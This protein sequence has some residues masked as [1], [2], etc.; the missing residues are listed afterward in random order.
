MFNNDQLAIRMDNALS[1]Q[2]MNRL[3]DQEGEN[4]FNE[5]SLRAALMLGLPATKKQ[6]TDYVEKHGNPNEAVLN[7]KIL[8]YNYA[9]AGN[10]GMT[11]TEL[12]QQDLKKDLPIAY[13]AADI[14]VLKTAFNNLVANP[15]IQLFKDRQDSPVD[16]DSLTGMIKSFEANKGAAIGAVVL[17]NVYLNL[18]TEYNIDLFKPFKLGNVPYNGFGGKIINGERKQDII[19]SLVTMETDNAKERFIS[20]LGLNI[21]AVGMAANMISLGIPLETTLLLLNSAEVRDLY[22]L[23]QNKVDNTSP[24]LK[25]LLDS[26]IA[27]LKAKVTEEKNKNGKVKFA[28]VNKDLL[29]KAVDST[30]DLSDNE[31]LQILYAFSRLNKIKNWTA[32]MRPAVVLSQGL[33]QNVPTTKKNIKDLQELFGKDAQADVTSI[34]KSKTWQSTNLKVFSQIYQD[35]LPNVLLTMS[36][37]FAEILSP[38]NDNLDIDNNKFGFD[39]AAKVEQDL[40]SYLTIKSYKHLLNNSSSNAAPVT[41]NLIYPGPINEADLS[42]VKMIRD[43]KTRRSENNEESNFFLDSFVGTEYATD[44]GNTTGLNIATSNTWRRLNAANLIDLQTSFAKLYGGLETRDLAISILHYM[45]VKDGLQLKYGSLLKA[46]SPFVME[47][48][49]NNVNTVELALK[50]I[51]PYEKA[52]GITKE[53]LIKE[54]KE[55]YLESNPTGPI[56]RNYKTSDVEYLPVEEVVYIKDEMED[57]GKMIDYFRLDLSDAMSKTYKLFKRDEEADVVDGKV[58]YRLVPSMGSNQQFAAGF[59]GGPRLTYIQTRNINSN[60]P[61]NDVIRSEQPIQQTD[62]AGASVGVSAVETQQKQDILRT[63]GAIIEVTNN[64]VEVKENDEQANTNIADTAKALEAL[65]DLT[66]SGTFDEVANAEMENNSQTLDT[67]TEEQQSQENQLKLDLAESEEMSEVVSLEKWWSDNVA[68]NT[69]AEKK[70][71][72]QGIN[73]LQDAMFAYGDLFSQTELGEQELI[74]RLKCLL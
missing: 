34:F 23:S 51:I 43:E 67:R 21:H 37:E 53:E 62:E 46:M 7:N 36:P 1:P 41:N 39:T 44:N 22:D 58:V 71:S 42:I 18:L 31:R 69:E 40:L 74:D 27:S 30:K 11:G 49:L 70:M 4:K 24:N 35:L 60:T 59:V 16:V 55:G 25:M 63:P 29:V 3:T 47:K 5:D 8:D 52:F 65:S 19:S 6:F 48:Y 33:P 56:L 10:E 66:A 64:S 13:Q 15:D 38:V 28:Q 61:V 72:E 17:P 68:G 12:L 54:F 14:E 2:E 57:N 45:M 73:S 26:R 50:G 32:K 9:L 20:K